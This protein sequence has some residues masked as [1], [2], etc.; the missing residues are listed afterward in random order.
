MEDLRVTIVQVGRVN[1]GVEDV[2]ELITRLSKEAGVGD[3]VL[4]PENWISG[5]PV[6]ISVYERV[7]T[8]I[9]DSLGSSIAGGLQYVVDV[10]GVIRSVGLAIIDGSLV[11]VCEKIHPSKAVGERGRVTPGRLMEPFRVKGWVVGCVACVDI[12]YPEVSR[13]LL[14]RGA[15]ILYNPAS[16]PENRVELWQSTVR[17]RGVENMVYAIGVNAFGNKY[18]D[19]RVTSGGSIASSP[20][21]K[22]LAL[23]GPQYSSTIVELN[24]ERVEEALERWAFKEDFEKHYRRLYI[25]TSNP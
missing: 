1:G 2:I 7:L 12:F 25:Q 21:G 18:P 8:S 16:I 17:V 3:L 19:G 11:R 20:W 4:L 23:L 9:Y 22:I 5:K 6:D 14:A 13:A 10:D 15:Q 24:W